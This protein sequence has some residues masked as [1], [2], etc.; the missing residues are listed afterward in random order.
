MSRFGMQLLTR[1]AS[2]ESQLK[3]LDLSDV[4]G[5]FV[6]MVMKT[7]LKRNYLEEYYT[8]IVIPLIQRARVRSP[9]GSDVLVEVFSSTIRQ[10]SRKLKP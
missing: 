1:N 4:N 3:N 10:M 6:V 8:N 9:D 2:L 7:K 5:T